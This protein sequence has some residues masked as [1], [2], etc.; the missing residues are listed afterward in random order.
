MK[1]NFYKKWIALSLGTAMLA[2]SP[3]G[4]L[5]VQAADITGQ[6]LVANE[7]FEAGADYWNFTSGAGIATNNVHSGT[8]HF[9]LNGG[10]GSYM[11]SQEITVP[12]AGI[13]E[14]SA[15]LTA[16]GAAGKFGVKTVDG[17]VLQEVDIQ[18][19]GY[20][21]Y[22]LPLM[23]FEQKTKVII[24]VTSGALWVNGDDFSF[25]CTEQTGDTDDT[26][27][28][29]F[30]GNM[31]EN[32]SFTENSGWVMN[33]AGYAQNNGH[34]GNGD[35]HF[36][37]NKYTGTIQ[38]QIQVPY[39]GYYK[40]GLW[41]ASAGT[42]AKY[43]VTN[44][45]TGEIQE[46][47][48]ATNT[49]YGEYSV[50]I[51]LNKGDTVEICVSGGSDWVNGDDIYLEYNASRFENMVVNPEFS[52]DTA[53]EK[54]GN[55]VVE[56]GS[57]ELSDADDSI[58]QSIYI[59][60]DGTY[61]AEVTLENADGAKVSFAG[62]ES[63]TVSGSTTVKVSVDNLKT[64]DLADLIISGKATVK[65]AVVMF[66][67]SAMPNEAPVAF[68]VEVQ[69]DCTAELVLEASY[70]FEDADGHAEGNSIYQWLLADEIDGEYTAIDGENAKN[71]V[72]KEEWEDQYLKFQV[73]PIDQYAKAG[74][75]AVSEAIGPVD[76][77]LIKNP[78]FE[79]NGANWTGISISNNSAYAGLNRGIVPAEGTA[80]QTIVVP[81]SAYYDFSGIVRYA[82]TK[83]DGRL[84]IQ[85]EAG[86]TLVSIAVEDAE[87]W[88]E[89]E[90]KMIPL[91]EG[92][93]I[94]VVLIGASDKTFDI[95][96]LCLKRNR[97][98]GV[99]VFTNVKAFRTAPDAF[100]TTIDTENHTIQLK[101]LYGTDLSKIVLQ[102]I[103]VSE[104]AET[105][106]K[107]GDELD[108][109][110]ELK[111]D[112]TGS[113]ESTEWTIQAEEREK[114]TVLTSAN[115]NLAD[116]FNWAVDKTDQFVMTGTEDGPINEPQLSGQTADYIPSYWA[117]YYDRTAFYARDFVHQ[118]TG[119][120]I[121]GL[122]A[123]NYSMFSAFAKECTEAR[124]WYTVW[125]LNFDGSVYTMDYIS[126]SYFVREIPAQFELVEKAYKQYLW[127]G[128]KRYIEDENLWNFYTNVMTNYVDSHDANGNGV[129][130]EV[131][132]G[133]F[134]GSSTYNERSGRTVIEA[135]DAIASQ[136]QATLAYAAMLKVRGEDDASQAW[137]Q[138]A[139]D[140]KTY[141]NEEWSVADEMSSEY[142]CAWG[143]NGERYSDFSKETSWFMPMKLITEP[144]ERNNAY[145]DFILENLG[146]GIGTTAAAPTN[147]EAYT[148]IPDMLFAYNRSDDA[149]KWM[150]YIASVKD[151]S[152]ERPAQGTN[153]DYPEISYTFVSQTVEGMMGVE[154]DAGTGFV[155][156]SPRLP[157]AVPDMTV[158]YLQVG[159]YELDLTHRS[160]TES[161]LTNHNL[162]KALSWEVRFYGNHKFIEVDGQIF[163]AE[164]KELNGETI[165][166]ITIT[167]EPGAT[168]NAKVISQEESVTRAKKVE[169][170]IDGLGTI[171]LDSKDVVAAARAAYEELNE[172][173]KAM[174]GNLPV[175]EDA[176][177]LLA[178]LEAAENV[179]APGD[180][181]KTPDSEPAM[182]D[183]KTPDSEPTTDDNKTPDSEPTTDDN[184][185]PGSEPATDDNKAP[186]NEPATDDNK[187]PD[188]EPT[189]DDNQKSAGDQNADN[190]QKP[191]NNQKTDNN[192]NAGG[193]K[194]G[195]AANVSGVLFAMFSSLS[196]AVYTIRK[197]KHER[198]NRKKRT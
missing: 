105:S 163:A 145:I 98:A 85:D 147:I 69:G 18:Q 101:Y 164:Q 99:P 195:D 19:G 63:E 171:T 139:A 192:K 137:Y 127:S 122:S 141:F 151:D 179:S 191:A 61:Y 117:G 72:V 45:T 175:L 150:E 144:G 46:C 58:C 35:R 39:T 113:E 132:T 55:A 173:E 51:W 123:E 196:G 104:G 65:E 64:P 49:K 131:G 100:E 50:E 169:E 34:N 126:D 30:D 190:N 59:P 154:P 73:T 3:T 5:A 194:T 162:D 90:S 114:K 149:W 125:A 184:K 92:Q 40:A 159:D 8:Q 160:N 130:Q 96:G 188:S 38:Q 138:K 66:D 107:E 110:D 27:D 158:Q 133:I 53:W 148:Y 78:G 62:A 102:E 75:T 121:V 178:E 6:N 135:G 74:E 44:I 165:S 94:N 48:L 20:Q 81:R 180:D 91:E 136:Y 70:Q 17:E 181:N 86:N 83:G 118:A 12:A 176:E 60:Q 157:S 16:G 23:T 4:A 161:A 153:G 112:V 183:N 88:K 177:K 155:A 9:Y 170:Q 2:G 108:L 21:E 1:K 28:Y 198:D 52:S 10:T 15:W 87:D 115:K 41:V 119:A 36:Y 24:Y 71:I 32:P 185:A 187:T 89:I 56:A 109:S 124:K 111:F 42:G 166:Y 43:T 57:A 120:Q 186:G 146:D 95:D 68:D 140:L 97:E 33:N 168:V 47:T 128:D 11:V 31:V 25:V 77:N 7:G 103:I 37:L 13:Y 172:E 84:E 116:T 80:A 79:S 134:N 54:N 93:T 22:T 106:I 143:A 156:T 193:V 14:A 174:V 167:V 29:T 182:D 26:P 197:K 82:G 142:V 76:L 67:V 189:T 129:A 152:H